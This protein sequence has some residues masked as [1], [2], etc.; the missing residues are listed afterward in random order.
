MIAKQDGHI[1]MQKRLNVR[2]LSLPAATNDHEPDMLFV[3]NIPEGVDDEFFAIFLDALLIDDEEDYTVK[4]RNECALITFT[5]KYSVQGIYSFHTSTVTIVYH[6]I[7][8]LL[9]NYFSDSIVVAKLY[10]ILSMYII[11]ICANLVKVYPGEK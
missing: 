11:Q 6:F 9:Y 1:F 8:L 3:Q 10:T 4:L 5:K 7:V 2:C